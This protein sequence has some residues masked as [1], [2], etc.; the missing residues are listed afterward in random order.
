MRNARMTLLTLVAL[1]LCLGG[2]SFASVPKAVM[3][4]DFTATW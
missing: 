2:A 3:I 1:S 4:E